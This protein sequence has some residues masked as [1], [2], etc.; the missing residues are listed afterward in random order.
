MKRFW[1]FANIVKIIS[2]NLVRASEFIGNTLVQIQVF[3][4]TTGNDLYTK[5]E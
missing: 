4:E 2:A 1:Y 5:P 3:N